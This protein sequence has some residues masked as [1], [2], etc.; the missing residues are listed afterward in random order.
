M[1][2]EDNQSAI[3]MARN[4]KFHGRMKQ[5]NMIKHHCTQQHVNDN[6][7]KLKCSQTSDIITD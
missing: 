7:T 2:H 1:L 4:P 6:D 3:A 5:I